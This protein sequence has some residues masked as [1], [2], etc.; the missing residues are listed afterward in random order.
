MINWFNYS[1]SCL[2]YLRMASTLRGTKL[3]Q[4]H[5]LSTSELINKLLTSALVE[6]PSS[7]GVASVSLCSSLCRKADLLPGQPI[8]ASPLASP[9]PISTLT[10]PPLSDGCR[11]TTTE[12]SWSKVCG[13]GSGRTA[14]HQVLETLDSQHVDYL[15]VKH[16]LTLWLFAH[17]LLV[18]AW[19][20]E[21]TERLSSVHFTAVHVNWWSVSITH[22][23]PCSRQHP[24]ISILLLEPWSQQ[25]VR[26]CLERDDLQLQ[27]I[28]HH[29]VPVILSAERIYIVPK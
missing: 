21:K 9:R 16:W 8:A 5:F 3:L 17:S 29:V 2:N 19:A 23:P 6:E 1:I 26:D 28:Y 12:T 15:L 14:T 25:V 24:P 13:L 4:V 10:T 11:M 20:S 7:S 18:E 27:V 22:V